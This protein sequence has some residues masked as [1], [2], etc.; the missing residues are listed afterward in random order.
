M[1]TFPLG[2]LVA[3]FAVGLGACDFDFVGFGGFRFLGFWGELCGLV[4][5][6]I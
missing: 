2:F 4:M 1:F 3:W 5:I 6:C